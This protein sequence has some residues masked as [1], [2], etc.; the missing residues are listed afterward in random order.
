[1]SGQ[2]ATARLVLLHE[3]HPSFLNL[4]RDRSLQECYRQH[5]ALISSET[6]QDSFYATKRAMLN[7]HPISD[8]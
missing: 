5:E 4:D 3:L 8:L 2:W 6:Q 7:F 1:L